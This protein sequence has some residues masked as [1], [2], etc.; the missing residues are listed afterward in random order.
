[1][2]PPP[3]LKGLPCQKIRLRER[4][5]WLAYHRFTG[6]LK[7]YNANREMYYL[8]YQGWELG[9]YKVRDGFLVKTKISLDYLAAEP[10]T[11][12]DVQPARLNKPLAKPNLF[13]GS[14]LELTNFS[15]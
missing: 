10:D 12:L 11:F 6:T 14:S 1:V 9:T 15:G 3:R 5:E 2:S 8:M 7:F 4:L 13:L